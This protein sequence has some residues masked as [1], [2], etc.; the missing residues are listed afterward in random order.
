MLK[1]KTFLKFAH[2]IG[3]FFCDIIHA[4]GSSFMETFF[5]PRGTDLQVMPKRK[6]IAINPT[7]CE[8]KHPETGKF[9]CDCLRWPNHCAVCEYNPALKNSK[10]ENVGWL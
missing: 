7:R 10:N 5:G 2:S 9:I 8:I 6:F 4:F 3:K 1:L